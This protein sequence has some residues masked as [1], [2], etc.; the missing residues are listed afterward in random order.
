MQFEKKSRE[1]YLD[2]LKLNHKEEFWHDILNTRLDLLPPKYELIK[3]ESS[4]IDYHFRKI[5]VENIQNYLISQESLNQISVEINK[6]QEINTENL[7]KIV[8][9]SASDKQPK[10]DYLFLKNSSNKW[11][12]F[13]EIFSIEEMIETGL[14]NGFFQQSLELLAWL[15]KAS[16]LIPFEFG[17]YFNKIF[18]KSFKKMIDFAAGNS[19]KTKKNLTTFIEVYK[20][21]ELLTLQKNRIFQMY[22]SRIYNE[23]MGILKRKKSPEHFCLIL[24]TFSI[25]F[26]KIF[27]FS[28]FLN[29]K[30]LGNFEFGRKHSEKIKEIVAI[31]LEK[32]IDNNLHKISIISNKNLFFNGI[33]ND[34]IKKKIKNFIKI[35]K[36]K[37][38][39]LLRWGLINCFFSA[40]NTVKVLKEINNAKIGKNCDFLAGFLKKN[41]F[42][43][44]VF[45]IFIF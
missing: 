39:L 7:S 12:N 44:A 24:E 15:Q 17:E 41:E 32:N 27:N 10:K 33:F 8:L 31:Y 13:S 30:I 4:K 20:N 38:K 1:N 34:V 5:A 16:Q 42:I 43:C 26:K 37:R 29:E 28:H 23:K 11:E 3:T 2:F 14:I 22:F 18:K 35:M 21:F 36:F 9:S 19:K 45:G 25:C 6:I 40:E